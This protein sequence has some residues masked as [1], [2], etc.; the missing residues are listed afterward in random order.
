MHYQKI[1]LLFNNY[2]NSI[3]DIKGQGETSELTF[4]FCQIVIRKPNQHAEILS[5]LTCLCHL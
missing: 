1:N 4:S 2:Y 5:L 3:K